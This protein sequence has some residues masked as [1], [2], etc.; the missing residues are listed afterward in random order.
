[1]KTDDLARRAEAHRHEP[2]PHAK[3]LLPSALKVR[4]LPEGKALTIIYQFCGLCRR[5]FAWR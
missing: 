5:V 1:M 4:P 2:V 3:L